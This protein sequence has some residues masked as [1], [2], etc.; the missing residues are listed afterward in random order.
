MSV[1]F[2]IDELPRF[3]CPSG[4]NF[5][6]SNVSIVQGEGEFQNCVVLLLSLPTAL[7]TS[8]V[9]KPAPLLPAETGTSSEVPNLYLEERPRSQST[10]ARP[11]AGDSGYRATKGNKLYKS[12]VKQ[13]EIALFRL[14]TL[15]SNSSDGR[16]VPACLHSHSTS[17]PDPT[18]L[19]ATACHDQQGTDPSTIA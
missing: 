19:F 3:Y 7:P 1:S 2:P 14:N 17:S 9:T 4:D 18:L 11:C 10:E 6:P 13:L 16:L 12:R 8:L 5:P 15:L